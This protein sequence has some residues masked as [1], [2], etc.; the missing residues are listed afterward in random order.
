MDIALDMMGGD[1][2]PVELV[3]AVRDY[4]SERNTLSASP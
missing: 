4:I 1:F 3:K 2:A